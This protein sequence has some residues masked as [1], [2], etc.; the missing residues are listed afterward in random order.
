MLL[1]VIADDFTGGSDVANTLAKGGMR[2]TQFVGIPSRPAAAECEAGVISLKSQT[3][4]AAGA[5]EQS[6]AACDWLLEQGCR[7]ILFKYCSTF[8][9]TP[10]GNIGP[11]AEALLH[12]LGGAAVVCPI[13]PATGRTLYNGH[14]F[15]GDRLLSETGMRD[16]PL[17]P[18]S[19]P[20]IRRWLRL[21]TKGEVGLVP[22]DKVRKGATAIRAAL[23]AETRAGHRLIITDALSDTDLRAIGE[24]VAND[25][26]VTGGSGIALG[27]PENFMKSGLIEGNAAPFRGFSGDGVA[28]S[29]SCS[30]QSLKQVALY[31]ARYPALPVAPE[32]VIHKTLTVEEATQWALDHLDRQP[33]IYSSATPDRVRAAQTEF[34]RDKAAQ[35]LE[36]FMAALARNLLEAGVRRFVIGGGETSGAIVSALGIEALQIGPEIDPGVPALSAGDH[37]FGVVLK[38][39]NF[40]GDDFY[41]RAFKALEMP[42]L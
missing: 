20:D 27:L 31:A 38:S 33:M 40:G 24:A 2:V 10:E 23:E 21:Q 42:Q 25:R 19:D 3:I 30:I 12:K 15:V 22:F 16:H 39:G 41:E 26:L 17:T 1:G 4:L 36:T 37:H 34:G 29:G 8:D 6:L 7:Q 14:L 9:S 28:I 32:A 18:M 13:F 35:A 11:V 5:V